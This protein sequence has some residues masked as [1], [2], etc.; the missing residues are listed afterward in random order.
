M[1]QTSRKKVLVSSVAM[2]MVAT[3]SLGSATFAW[4]SQKTTATANG[5]TASTTAASNLR[6]SEDAATWTYD[7]N[8]N[9]AKTLE[10]ASTADFTKW[11]TANAASFDDQ[12]ADSI[13]DV[14]QV[15]AANTDAN[16]YC[17][18]KDLYFNYTGTD[19]ATIYYKITPS[20]TA[21][22]TDFLR[23]A[24]VDST[25]AVK[26]VYENGT[27][28]VAPLTSEDGA[29]GTLATTTST[30][31]TVQT[32]TGDGSSAGTTS[33]KYTIYI[34]FEGQDAQCID[35]NAVNTCPVSF[36]FATT[37]FTN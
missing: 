22:S 3:V 18:K 25:G 24:L 34:W 11:F 32:I 36:D 16:K 35:T 10:P 13:T 33:G 8:Y 31:G 9:T 7:L 29:T 27:E 26:F 14:S 23:V 5:L 21:G 6:I 37:E 4:F 28:A 30:K 1:K 17:I 12:T 19:T 15:V 2:M 20:S